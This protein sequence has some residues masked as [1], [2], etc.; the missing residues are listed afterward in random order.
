MF[1]VIT[2]AQSFHWL[3]QARVASVARAMLDPS[4]AVVHVGATTHGRSGQRPTRG[5]RVTSCAR[6]SVRSAAPVPACFP[7]A[8]E[9][10]GSGVRGRGASPALRA[11]TSLPVRCSSGAMDDVVRVRFLH[12]VSGAASLWPNDAATSR[13]DLRSILRRASPGRPLPRARR[14]HRYPGLAGAKSGA[15]ARR[16]RSEPRSHLFAASS[17]SSGTITVSGSSSPSVPIAAS[18]PALCR[19]SWSSSASAGVTRHHHFAPSSPLPAG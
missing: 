5:D 10:R 4:G 11:S 16:A 14:R 19:S 8:H 17:E 2:F 7:T 12:V 1:A 13:A 15:A 6:I 9:R 18:M 3:E